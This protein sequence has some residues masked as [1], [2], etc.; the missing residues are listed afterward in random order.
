MLINA[1]NIRSA[2]VGFNAAFKRGL[3]ADVPSEWQKM[4]MEVMSTG[5]AE[6]YGWIESVPSLKEWIG[7]REVSNLAASDYTLKNKV[8]ANA[9]AIPRPKFEDDKYGLFNTPMEDMGYTARVWRDQMLATLIASATTALCYDGLPFLSASHVING[10]TV[11]NYDT[12]GG[13]LWLLLDTRRPMKPFI[14]QNRQSPVLTQKTASD[15]ETVFNT[16]EFVFGTRARGAAGFGFWQLAHGSKDTLNSTNYASAKA[17]MKALTDE[18]GKPL[19]IR[20][21]LLVVGA[22]NEVAA[23]TLIEKQ[24]LTGGE[25]NIYFNDVEVLYSNYLD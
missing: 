14:M 6:D 24:N 20:P 17:A 21:N 13:D 10:A 25:S 9:V 11:S 12:A 8:Y 7:P 4:A 19:G 18:H 23:K 22:S 1:A 3:A 2:F 5:E 16:D 15:D